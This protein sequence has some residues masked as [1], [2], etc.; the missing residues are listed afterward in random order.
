MNFWDK[1]GVI[2]LNFNRRS[3]PDCF[4]IFVCKWFDQINQ[5]G[6]NISRYILGC[7]IPQLCMNPFECI[8]AQIP[9]CL[10]RAGEVSYQLCIIRLGWLVGWLVIS[11]TCGCNILSLHTSAWESWGNTVA[12][13]ASPGSK[14]GTR[15]C[16]RYNLIQ[17]EANSSTS[18]P[19]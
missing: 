2:Y 16:L 11:L 18:N 17:I 6:P 12:V 19:M 3:P 7:P 15:I 4:F 5:V 1:K 14:T 9:G 10:H 8:K 13:L